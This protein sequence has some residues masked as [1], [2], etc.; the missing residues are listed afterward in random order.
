MKT[1]LN[2]MEK[3]SNSL[4]TRTIKMKGHRYNFQPIRLAQTQKFYNTLLASNRHIPCDQGTILRYVRV[5]CMYAGRKNLTRQFICLCSNLNAFHAQILPI[6]QSCVQSWHRQTSPVLAT[7]WP[8]HIHGTGHSHRCLKARGQETGSISLAPERCSLWQ[9]VFRALHHSVPV[10]STGG[11][12]SKAH[13]GPLASVLFVCVICGALC[14]MDSGARSKVLGL[15]RWCKWWR[16][17]L[18]MQETWVL[19]IVWENPTCLGT[20]KA[21]CHKYWACALEPA[22]CNYWAHAP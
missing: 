11:P 8:A 21:V 18:P 5:Y 3:C 14:N 20:T 4:K 10:L 2:R 16:T 6:L 22:I 19:S 1:V 17:H 15:P 12:V 9:R 7:A 13:M